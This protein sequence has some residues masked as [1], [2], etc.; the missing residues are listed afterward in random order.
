[1]VAVARVIRRVQERI[2]R[3]KQGSPDASSLHIAGKQSVFFEEDHIL[4]VDFVIITDNIKRIYFDRILSISA[5]DKLSYRMLILF[6][7]ISLVPAI[8]GVV[9]VAMGAAGKT[10]AMIAIGAILLLLSFIT[11]VLAFVLWKRG[12]TLFRVVTLDQDVQEFSALG[13]QEKRYNLYMRLVETV[14]AFRASNTESYRKINEP[15]A[16][17]QQN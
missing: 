2:T 9:L 11:Q 15:E 5:H 12:E 6:L 3:C 17:V 7:L 13:S 8:P 16:H 1:M 4:L 10:T 14:R